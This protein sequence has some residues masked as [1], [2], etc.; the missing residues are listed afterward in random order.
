MQADVPPDRTRL[1]YF[2]SKERQNYCLKLLLEVQGF[3]NQLDQYHLLEKL[4]EGA[5]SQVML[6][7]HRSTKEKFAIK[8][9]PF[10]YYNECHKESINREIEL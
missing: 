6:A 2:D 1:L 9:I 7:Q 3:Q 4:G 8:I 5:F 10:S